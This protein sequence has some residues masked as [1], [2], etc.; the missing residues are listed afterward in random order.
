[1]RRWRLLTFTIVAGVVATA[2]GSAGTSAGNP[3]E[4]TGK[5]GGKL[6]ID[7]E[8]GGT[9]SC[10]FNPFNSG[11]SG[12]SIGFTYE[13]LSF[14]DA[15]ATNSDGSNKVTPWLASAYR[16]DSGFTTLTFTIR[17]GVRWSDGQPFSAQDVLYTFNAMKDNSALDINALWQSDGVP[18]TNVALQGSNQVVITFSG[19]AQ[20]YF[21]YVADQTP[22]VP[23]HIWGSKDQAKLDSYADS[24]PIGTGP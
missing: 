19:P 24:Q 22:I 20:T 1:M 12:T 16:W 23:Q 10:Q 17:D 11:V 3:Q 14:V 9:W 5:I 2:C 7:N 8:S 15:L 4:N 13:P 21:F 6:V 18:V